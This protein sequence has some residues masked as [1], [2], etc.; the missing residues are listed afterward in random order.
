MKNY[1]NVSNI[2]LDFIKC[3]TVFLFVGVVHSKKRDF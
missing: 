2:L 3:V 1:I